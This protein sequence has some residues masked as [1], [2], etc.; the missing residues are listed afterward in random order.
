MARSALPLC[1]GAGR[2]RR[3]WLAPGAVPASPLVSTPTALE[4]PPRCVPVSPDPEQVVRSYSSPKESHCAPL[5]AQS[6]GVGTVWEAAMSRFKHFLP[7]CWSLA[8]SIADP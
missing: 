3:G 2:A 7:L 5:I 4:V 6:L 1:R 8:L